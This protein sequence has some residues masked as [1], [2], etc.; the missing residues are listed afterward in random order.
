MQTQFPNSIQ[1]GIS[2]RVEIATPDFPAP[3]WQARAYLRGP[4]V[5]DLVAT[6]EGSAH[7]FYKGYAET[8][9]WVDGLYDYS[10]KVF[11]STDAFEIERGQ[12]RIAID[13]MLVNSTYDARRHE[14]RVLDAVE[15]V[16]EG[17]ATK[18]QESYTINGR[19]LTRTPIADLLKLRD[20]YRV[21][22]ARMS[23]PRARRLLRRQVK[24]RM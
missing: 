2:L 7:L 24:V 15:A 6:A 20:H 16:I 8:S 22:V 5:I 11:D 17:R 18:D 21:E 12:T 19:T 10:I 13:K 23:R 3:D 14:Q 4:S 1:A 9:N